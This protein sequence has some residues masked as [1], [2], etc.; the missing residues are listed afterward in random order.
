ME[1]YAEPIV[2]MKDE[3]LKQF[4][5][6][7]QEDMVET[8]WKE[9]LD[10]ND[11][12]NMLSE[13][14]IIVNAN[15][16]EV[17]LKTG[18]EFEK[19]FLVNNEFFRDRVVKIRKSCPDVPIYTVSKECMD[20]F[21]GNS[22]VRAICAVIKKKQLPDIEELVDKARNVVV[23]EDVDSF[24]TPG[25]I[26]RI[27]ACFGMDAVIINSSINCDLYWKG[28]VSSSGGNIFYLPWTKT[29]MDP[30]R[31]NGYLKNKGFNI[32]NF[33]EDANNAESLKTLSNTDK[34]WVIVLNEVEYNEKERIPFVIAVAI[35]VWNM[36]KAYLT[37]KDT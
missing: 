32:V 34:K 26:A 18:Q 35:A 37:Q 13:K 25:L 1:F 28:N 15:T 20:R 14:M 4:N 22:R 30:E 33:S 21:I 11:A 23:I 31:L 29:D 16:I 3:E 5:I 9:L 12:D 7:T 10:L 19:V 8:A 24:R 2:P 27:C 17:A 6:I 36:R